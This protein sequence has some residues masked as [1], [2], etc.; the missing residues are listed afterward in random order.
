MLANAGLVLLLS[1]ALAGLGWAFQSDTF[2]LREVDVNAT[3][4]TVRQ[5]IEDMVAP[6][7]LE[8]LPGTVECPE[9]QLGPNELTLSTAALQRQLQQ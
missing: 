4:T 7:C 6:G 9:A 8:S 1:G 5:S 3:S 2:R